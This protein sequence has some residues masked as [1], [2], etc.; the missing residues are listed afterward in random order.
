MRQDGGAEFISASLASPAEAGEV[1][2]LGGG[3]RQ[4][5]TRRCRSC[6]WDVF[7]YDLFPVQLRP[8]GLLLGQ[9]SKP[10]GAPQMKPLFLRQRR[11]Q[12]VADWLA[13]DQLGAGIGTR[14]ALVDKD[15]VT[16]AEV[17][18]QSRRRVDDE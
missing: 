17:V 7:A 8:T 13:D 6:S 10:I 4:P 11:V 5:I 14:L 16:A 3:Q 15:K 18:D 2:S 1:A 12:H 9:V